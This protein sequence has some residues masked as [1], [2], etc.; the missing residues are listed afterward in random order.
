LDDSVVPACLSE[1]YVAE[2]RGRGDCADYVPLPGVGHMDLID[3]ASGA[4]A[5]AWARLEVM[6]G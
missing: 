6:L 4:W 1:R 5:A 2:A 3:P